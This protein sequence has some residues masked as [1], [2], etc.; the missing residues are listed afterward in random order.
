MEVIRSKHDRPG[1][2]L[3]WI[4]KT[5]NRQHPSTVIICQLRRIHPLHPRLRPK[6]LDIQIRVEQ[7]LRPIHTNIY[8]ARRIQHDAIHHARLQRD[9]LHLLLVLLGLETRPVAPAEIRHVLARQ[10]THLVS[11][12]FA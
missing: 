7:N 8:T 11:H 1:A 6:P 3:D 4:R 9:L 2:L 5:T 12:W 10:V